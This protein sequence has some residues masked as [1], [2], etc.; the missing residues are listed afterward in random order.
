MGSMA[1]Y[2]LLAYLVIRHVRSWRWRVAV[3]LAG[4]VEGSDRCT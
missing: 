2:G 3:A 4:E 1:F